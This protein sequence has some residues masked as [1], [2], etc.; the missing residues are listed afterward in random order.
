MAG[1]SPASS[2]SAVGGPKEG[3]P[4]QFIETAKKAASQKTQ[5]LFLDP[6]RPG[7]VTFTS[8]T[9]TKLENAT[10]ALQ[11]W[12][13]LANSLIVSE[14]IGTKELKAARLDGE[15]LWNILQVMGFDLQVALEG[16]KEKLAPFEKPAVDRAKA[17]LESVG[18]VGAESG[19]L[20]KI[21]VLLSKAQALDSLYDAD[22]FDRVHKELEKSDNHFSSIEEMP[23]EWAEDFTGAS[24]QFSSDA[25]NKRD[26]ENITRDAI[27]KKILL[28]KGKSPSSEGAA[29]EDAASTIAQETP[30]KVSYAKVAAEEIPSA[31]KISWADMVEEDV[32]NAVRQEQN[33]ADSLVQVIRTKKGLNQE[34]RVILP[35]NLEKQIPDL[36][37]RFVIAAQAAK[38]DIVLDSRTE[39]KASRPVLWSGD[40]VARNA[41]LE[42]LYDA[43]GAPEQ[44]LFEI[45]DLGVLIDSLLEIPSRES[46]ER[47][48][49]G[50]TGTWYSVNLVARITCE[51][52][53]DV[54][55]AK[56][57]N[58]WRTGNDLRAAM[59]VSLT[60]QLG[61]EAPATVVLNAFD[62]IYRRFI[63]FIMREAPDDKRDLLWTLV[64]D[65]SKVLLVS[66]GGLFTNLLR[67]ETRKKKIEQEEP[68]QGGRKTV[69]KLVEVSYQAK[70]R[71][72]ITEGPKTP[73]ESAAYAKVNNALARIESQAK[74]YWLGNVEFS[75]PMNWE[76][77]HHSWVESL[78]SKVRIPSHLMVQRKQL[79][80]ATIIASMNAATGAAGTPAGNPNQ[81]Q[82][83]ISQ[84]KWIEQQNATLEAHA[85]KY[86]KESIK[87]LS[88]MLGVTL[89]KDALLKLT[90]EEIITLLGAVSP[91]SL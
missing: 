15:K 3:S 78:Y 76:E 12:E 53:Y 72:K 91:P 80:R 55:I 23:A 30:K 70:V 34:N 6:K 64:A 10:R 68:V 52:V 87:A 71:P 9:R 26:A 43:K 39:V 45:A 11:E 27:K 74:S 13:S 57:R 85:D 36:H 51:Q 37:R 90:E 49:P 56:Q 25:L 61:G 84:T 63:R 14:D 24:E 89:D 66:G 62:I 77:A 48:G 46:I 73:F 31:P 58:W 7:I 54:P 88:I 28:L 83:K 59:K 1:T 81:S 29:K 75:D 18:E 60:N 5:M 38:C 47:R 33:D 22:P 19:T 40:K 69:K 65:Y 35:A 79:I 86:E 82:A 8:S 4:Q 50:R 2:T 67:S 41:F 21:I 17:I 42:S 44:E 16:C 32:A 20:G